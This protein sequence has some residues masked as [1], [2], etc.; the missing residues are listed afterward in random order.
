MIDVESVLG[1]LPSFDTFCSVE[2]LCRLAEQ[3]REDR[4]FDVEII[5][6]SV[7][8]VPI[9]HVRCGTGSIKA[10]LVGGPHA[11]EPIGSLT[12]FSLMT[13][14]HQG[15]REL[16]E[17]D[18][19][20]HIVP[21]IDPDGALLNEGWSQKPFTFENYLKNF[22]LQSMRDMVDCSFPVSH[23]KLLWNELSHEAAILKELLDRMQPDFYY[24]LHNAWIGGAFYFISHD[25]GRQYHERLHELLDR[26]GMPIQRR[27][28]WREV[29]AQYGEGIIEMFDVTKHYDYVEKTSPAPEQIVRYGASSRYYL[30]QIKPGAL[31]FVT[32]MGYVR[33]PSDESEAKTGQNLRKFLLR[34]DADNKFLASVL[35]E[36]WDKVKD[37][38]DVTSPFY[39]AIA[40]GDVFP[41]TREKLYD[42]GM[43]LSFYPTRDVLFNSKYDREMTEADRFNSCMINSGAF[44]TRWSYQF[45]RLLKQSPQTPAVCRALERLEAAFA[46]ARADIAQHIDFDAF[47]V[48]DCDTLAKIQLG[49]GLI[50]LNSLLDA[51]SRH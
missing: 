7:G 42:G 20:W 28:L 13:L 46:Q 1:E 24:G 8:G 36:E 35:L 4:R 18:V 19:E 23:K 3:L 48:V 29:C 49:S 5:G 22:Y 27:P 41:L 33:H 25:I 47:Q 16:L 6:N 17:A 30:T 40:A 10:L 21:C 44:F 2:K 31:T 9:H 26:H 37:Q 14:I 34:L 51:P 32:E 39:R 43:P 15:N 12:V 50:V 38:V 45:V 11:M